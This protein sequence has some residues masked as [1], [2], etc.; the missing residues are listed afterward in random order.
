MMYW[1]VHGYQGQDM[2]HGGGTTVTA[3]FGS[4]IAAGKGAVKLANK[5]VQNV[6]HYARE[7]MCQEK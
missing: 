4:F 6:W 3:A 5:N 2:W 1:S 7:K